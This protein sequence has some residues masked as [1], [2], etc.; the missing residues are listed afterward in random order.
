MG[1][2]A[3]LTDLLREHFCA[4]YWMVH[5][6]RA[7][8]RKNWTLNRS[9]QAVRHKNTQNYKYNII[10][11]QSSSD[12]SRNMRTRQR[13]A[14]YKVQN[15]ITPLTLI[16]KAEHVLPIRFNHVQDVRH[17]VMFNL[18]ASDVFNSHRFTN[19]GLLVQAHVNTLP[20]AGMWAGRARGGK[21]IG[22]SFAC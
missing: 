18:W 21:L 15:S 10:H 9:R 2:I 5:Y 1:K 14:S 16:G 13:C 7:S 22:L 4:G 12:H 20:T 3:G 17:I 11:N 6:R 19:Q 8:C